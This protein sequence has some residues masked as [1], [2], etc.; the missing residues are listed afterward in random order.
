MLRSWRL[1][2]LADQITRT[3]HQ[4][5]QLDH[6][7][8]QLRS[9]AEDARRDAI[10]AGGGEPVRDARHAER[11]VTRLENERERQAAKLAQLEH[12]L[13]AMLDGK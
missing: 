13:D 9:D 4:I 5:T 6:E 3:R 11:S 7:L 2:R 8:V 1:E 10:V 12:K